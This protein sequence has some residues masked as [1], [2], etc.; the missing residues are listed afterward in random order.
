L[1]AT[2][3]TAATVTSTTAPAG[4]ASS[5][6]LQLGDLPDGWQQRQQTASAPVA[7]ACLVDE[8]DATRVADHAEAEFVPSDAS[9]LN[10]RS[11]VVLMRTA[12]DAEAIVESVRNGTV[13]ECV[14]GRIAAQAQAAGAALADLS[15][16]AQELDG[17]AATFLRYTLTLNGDD[18]AVDQQQVV[19]A[20]GPFVAILNLTAGGRDVPPDLRSDL[21]AH[22]RSRL[23]S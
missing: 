7:G 15:A 18:T 19:L 10:V 17:E 6:T 20:S 3:T 8:S 22:V 23:G 9:G 12:A 5:K 14:R 21:L 1:P 11:T 16:E 2:S 4:Q 13:A